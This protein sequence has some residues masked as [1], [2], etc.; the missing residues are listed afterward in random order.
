M[1]KTLVRKML[2]VGGMGIPSLERSAATKKAGKSTKM[3]DI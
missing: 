3:E 1:L 2:Q